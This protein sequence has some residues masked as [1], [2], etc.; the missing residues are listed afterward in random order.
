M[1]IT[2]ARLQQRRAKLNSVRQAHR[3]SPARVRVPESTSSWLSFNSRKTGSASETRLLLDPA[4]L[5][6]HHPYMGCETAMLRTPRL[7]SA[8]Y[9]FAVLAPLCVLAN[10]SVEAKPAKD[11]SV[12]VPTSK[13]GPARTDLTPRN[14]NDC[15]AVAQ[16]LNEQAKRLSQQA[17]QRGL[18][19][20][21]ARVASD[22]D[23]S[24]GA[25][26]FQKAWISIE[27]MNGCLNNFVKDA[28]LGFC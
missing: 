28:E 1:T 15:L 19:R 4:L 24:C 13:Q 3:Q 10:L 17:K 20:E 9:L 16:A 25:G 2:I 22:P 8:L 7:A 5:T 21:F 11:R 27:W 18:P 6:R 26:D 12:V 14:R 23:Q